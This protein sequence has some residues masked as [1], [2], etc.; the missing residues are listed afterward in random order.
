[1]DKD[2]TSFCGL[3]CNDCIPG[4]EKLYALASELYQLLMD[5]DLKDYVKLKSQKVA[6]FR[7]YDI[8]INVLE[9]F[10]KLHCYNYCRKGP[11]S[12]AGCAQS[13]K[14]RVCAIKKG[15]EGCWEC[16]AYFS[17]EYIAEMQLFHPDIKHN[18]AMIK[19]LGTDNWQE[20]RGRHYNW[21]KQLGIRFT[22]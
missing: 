4:N 7:D 15:L 19:E 18:L 8:F 13:C 2:L 1:M 10:E 21:S 11:C 16:N 14:V 22:P 6:E 3:W 5:I 12:E 20:R 17:C 9:A